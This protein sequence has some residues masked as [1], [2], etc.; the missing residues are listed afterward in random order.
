MI[1][2]RISCNNLIF[3]SSN[4]IAITSHVIWMVVN[5]I[6]TVTMIV[7]FRSLICPIVGELSSM[8]S[9]IATM[10]ILTIYA[11]Y[12]INILES[13]HKQ[14]FVLRFWR[15]MDQINHYYT[16]GL[17]IETGGFIQKS[18]RT[19]YTIGMIF[20]IQTMLI[21]FIFIMSVREDESLLKFYGCSIFFILMTRVGEVYHIFYIV[22]YYQQILLFKLLIERQV[23]KVSYDSTSN[24]RLKQEIR[25]TK[26]L[27]TIYFEA[28]EVM[29]GIFTM[30]KFFTV[31]RWIIQITGFFYWMLTCQAFSINGCLVCVGSLLF[32]Y[33]PILC[34]MFLL[35]FYCE[36]CMREVFVLYPNLIDVKI[37]A[38]LMHIFLRFRS[39]R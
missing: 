24:K 6:L 2:F 39:I 31:W 18:K 3:F 33:I 14:Q 35:Y 16:K 8:G 5:L 28:S 1:F 22:V 32:Y 20:F 11:Q 4:Q 19:I 37:Y 38:N 36:Q 30:T 10:Q 17:N 29:N 26:M 9:I 15:Q 23:E 21:E 7:K 13:L 12:L 27:H 34:N 25:M